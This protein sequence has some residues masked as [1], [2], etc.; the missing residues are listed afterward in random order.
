[1]SDVKRVQEF[2]RFQFVTIRDGSVFFQTWEGA[3]SHHGVKSVFI[4]LFS[5]LHKRKIIVILHIILFTS[6]YCVL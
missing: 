5:I 3:N 6:I 2:I 4:E 1:M